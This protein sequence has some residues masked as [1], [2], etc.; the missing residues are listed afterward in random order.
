MKVGLVLEGGAMRGLYTA[1]VMDVMMYNNII[2]DGIIGVSAG[3]LFGVN[4]FSRQRGRVIR[5]SKR[6]SKDLRYISILSKIFTGNVVNKNFA[7]YKV[8]TKLDIFDDEEFVKNNKCYYAVLTDVKTGKP[9]YKKIDN[10]LG[11]LEVLR[12]SSALPMASK[13]VELDNKFYLDGGISDAIPVMKCKKLGFDKIII[14]LT[15]PYD[16]RKTAINDRM[17]KKL[18]RKFKKYPKLVKTMID[19]YKNYNKII[20]KIIKMEKNGEIFVIRPSKKI[21]IKLIERDQ[22]KLQDVYDLGINDANSVMEDLK[23]YLEI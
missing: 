5:Y 21:D 20:E 8:P 3:A 23:K 2:V 7:F 9:E 4:Y 22:N 11:S 1:G 15:Q 14:I 17:I 10:C 19:R 13:L 18:N 16:Y 12:A 6:F